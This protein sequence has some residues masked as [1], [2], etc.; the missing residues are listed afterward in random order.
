MTTNESC[1]FGFG[2]NGGETTVSRM[3]TLKCLDLVTD[4]EC[5][6][7]KNEVTFARV[8]LRVKI[9]IIVNKVDLKKQKLKSKALF[10]CR[11]REFPK[12][13]LPTLFRSRY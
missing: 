9:A 12:K 6:V 10:V 7:E 11:W 1:I 4:Q 13:N 8:S 3:T 2:N 5:K